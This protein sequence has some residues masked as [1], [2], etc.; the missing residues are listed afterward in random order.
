[1]EFLILGGMILV[2]SILSK[3]PTLKEANKALIA[4]KLPIGIVI[5]LVGCSSFVKGAKFAFQGIM[6]LVGGFLLV[7]DLLKL[8]PKGSETM[9]RVD[10]AITGFQVPIGLLTLLAGMI[11]L[12]IR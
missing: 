6:G 2:M 4:L 10:I 11:G 8:I 3:V 12:F 9:E 5:I 1:M 7:I